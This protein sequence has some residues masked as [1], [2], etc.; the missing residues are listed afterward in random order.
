MHEFTLDHLNR[1][2]RET[3]GDGDLN[4]DAADTSFSDLGYDSLAM[5]EIA[6]RIGQDFMV[7]LSDDAVEALVTPTHAVTMVN[8]L[9]AGGVL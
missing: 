1:I 7:L 5:L 3:G 4:G 8:R 2:M 6:A 9:L